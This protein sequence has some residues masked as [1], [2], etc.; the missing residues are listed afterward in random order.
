MYFYM[1][2]A[3]VL[4][5]GFAIYQAGLDLCWSQTCNDL[6]ASVSHVLGLQDCYINNVTE[7]Q[8]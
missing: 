1:F 8:L 2:V 5:Q 3:A 6:P 4:R 7:L